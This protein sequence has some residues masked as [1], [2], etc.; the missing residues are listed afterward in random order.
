ADGKVS[1]ALRRQRLP[2]P[3]LKNLHVDRQIF[4]RVR[5]DCSD[6]SRAFRQQFVEIGVRLVVG[7]QF[8]KS[9]LAVVD[10]GQKGVQ[11]GDR[12]IQLAGEGRIFHQQT[13]ATFAG[14]RFRQQRIGVGQRRVQV[15]VE[16]IVL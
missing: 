15:V 3:G 10:V 11:L 13:E 6:Q 14:I 5:A 12:V 7:R 2:A 1:P 9:P 16:R 8:A 4:L